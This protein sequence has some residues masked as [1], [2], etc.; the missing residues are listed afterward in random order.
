MTKEEALAYFDNRVMALGAVFEPPIS[1]QT[2]YQWTEVPGL[3]Q[4]QLQIIT[5]GALLADEGLIPGYTV[6]RRTG[7]GRVGFERVPR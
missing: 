3:R 6:R 1:A 7:P 4:I 2:I 5:G